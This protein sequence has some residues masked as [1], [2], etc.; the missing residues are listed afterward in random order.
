M[1]S[2][3]RAVDGALILTVH[4]QPGAKRNEVVGP[5][6]DALKI[7]VAA[8][9]IDGRAN[10]ALCEFVAGCLGMPR[11]AVELKSGLSTRHK[12]LRVLG[13]PADA[14]QRLFDD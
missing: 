13:A 5:H 2:W 10:V 3:L 6:G 11:A 9:A 8:P 7:R 14:A 12:V 1:P 4:A